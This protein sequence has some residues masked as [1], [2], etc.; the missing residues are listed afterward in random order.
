MQATAYRTPTDAMSTTTFQ[1]L[2]QKMRSQQTYGG[3]PQQAGQYP[4]PYQARHR[5]HSKHESRGY[6]RRANASAGGDGVSG[7]FGGAGS[8]MGLALSS[9]SHPRGRGERDRFLVDINSGGQRNNGAAP[10]A[11][12]HAR[13]D[14]GVGVRVGRACAAGGR[15]RFGEHS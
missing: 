13:K 9:C 5:L 11:L 6:K 10:N 12:L 1:S 15:K 7:T 14:V 4:S 8:G 3:G 2:S